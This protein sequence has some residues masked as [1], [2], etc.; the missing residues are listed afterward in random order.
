MNLV[1]VESPAKAKTINKFLGKKYTVKPSMGHLIDLPKSQ[2]G[3]EPEADFKVKYITIRGRGKILAEL[4][5][6]AAKAD[7]VYLATDPDREGEAIAWHLLKEFKLDES[8]PCRVEFNEITKQAIKKAFTVPRRLDYDLVD[9]QQARRVLDRLVG[10]KISPILW[11]KVKR[12][13]SAGRVQSA[14]LNMLCLRQEEIDS[15]LPREYWTIEGDFQIDSFRVRALLSQ[16]DG[17]KPALDNEEAAAAVVQ[18]VG[19]TAFS[20]SKL[21][22]KSRKKMPKPP[23]ITS[24]LQ[25]QAGSKLNFSARKTMSIAQQLYEGIALGKR[26]TTGLITYMRTDSVR[27]SPEIQEA[28]REY[29]AARF[30]PEYVPDSPPVYHSRKGAQEAHEAIRPT[31]VT[32]VPEEIQAYLTPEQFSLYRL[33]WQRYVMSQ[34]KPALYKQQTATISGGNLVFVASELTLIFPGFLAADEGAGEK[35]KNGVNLEG[36]TAGSPAKIADVFPKQHFTQPPPAYSEALL[37]KEMEH[38][39]IG[40][41]STYAPTIDTLLYRGYAEKKNTALVPT[42]LGVTVNNLL[43]QF[44]PDILNLDFTAELENRLD[45]VG[46]GNL[47]WKQVVANF[48]AKFKEDVEVAQREMDMVTIEDEITDELCEHCGRN[49]VIKRGRFGKFLACPGYPQCKNTKPLL[50][51]I[52]VPCPKCG[53]EIVQRRSKKGRSFYGCENYP[54]CDFVS[55]KRPVE[56]KCPRCQSLL[57][58][59]NKNVLACSNPDCEFK[60]MREEENA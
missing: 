30:S 54:N 10:Y 57:V 19:E 31:D 56:E 44:F 51:K 23:L 32:L 28:T 35:E 25:Q 17:E 5:K 41:P 55:W 6:L 59:E 48:Y 20:L 21:V 8:V 42:E 49:M 27:V 4:R 12:G 13:L 1:I 16:I 53:G 14:A 39:E 40:R 26:G 7:F 50:N 45:Q 22:S 36:L 2:L 18:L 11:E 43:R 3:V 58:I 47:E 37:V 29:L 33:I 38:K 52:N 15:F 60:A 46:E 9:A 34:M 24:T